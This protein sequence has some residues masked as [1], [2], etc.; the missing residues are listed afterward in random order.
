[1]IK[2]QLNQYKNY[3]NFIT[4]N[5]DLLNSL[6]EEEK[7]LLIDTIENVN[8]ISFKDILFNEIKPLIFGYA[9]SKYGIMKTGLVLFGINSIKKSLKSGI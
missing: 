4:S 1:M 3:I 2:I 5:K 6:K 8:K 9:I 7:L